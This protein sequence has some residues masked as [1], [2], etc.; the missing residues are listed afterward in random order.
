MTV[1]KRTEYFTYL[2]IFLCSTLDNIATPRITNTSMHHLINIAETKSQVIYA[3]KGL[4]F[5][6][7]KILDT[8]SSDHIYPCTPKNI[9][10]NM[11]NPPS[12]KWKLVEIFGNSSLLDTES[13]LSRV[14]E[15]SIK[16]N[17]ENSIFS[18]VSEKNT[19]WSKIV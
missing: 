7:V 8:L 15:K 11:Y 17:E 3:Q 19:P 5:S 1:I 14:F 2:I 4:R 18:P 12:Q 10:D 9:L 6:R 16:K 13:M